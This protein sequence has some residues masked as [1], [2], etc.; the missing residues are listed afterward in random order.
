MKNIE[1]ERKY[2]EL[3]GFS[4]D[5]NT[6]ELKISGYPAIFNK[7]DALNPS[8]HPELKKFVLAK[9]IMYP[10]CFEKTLSERKSRV[11]LC[12][13]HNMENPVGKI[14]ELK[15]D[16][17]GLSLEARISDSEIELKTKIREEILKEMSFGYIV[18]K[19]KM[20]SKDDGTWIRHIYEVK[21]YECSIV[22]NGRHEDAKITEVKSDVFD[23]LNAM[24]SKEN[25]EEKKY[26]LLQI[27]SLINDEPIRS[28]ETEE[29]INADFSEIKNLFK[30]SLNLN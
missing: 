29:P 28:L 19:A 22:T 11:A 2:F 9:D 7:E 3:K 25:N 20:E 10:G 23:I 1:L 14:I 15:E 13:N 24:I 4:P 21:L 12:R 27:K 30:N 18:T 6:E 26:Q 8:Y 5:D 16:E 17:T